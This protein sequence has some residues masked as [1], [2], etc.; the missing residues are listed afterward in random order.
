MTEVLHSE[1]ESVIHGESLLSEHDI[2]LFKEGNHFRMY[3]KL[4]SHTMTVNGREG[5]FF[6]LWAPNA[7]AVSVIGDFNCWDRDSHHLKPR[8][9]GSGIWEGFIPGIK[10]GDTYKYYIASQYHMYRADKGDPYALHW[11]T[12]PKT[13]SIVWDL[14]YEWNDAEWMAGRRARNSLDAP[15]SIY[16]VH[17]GSWLKI[18]RSLIVV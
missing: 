5:T 4:G 2:Y 8:W 17:L 12:P 9:D 13:A 3:D 6:A 7:E 16:E 15:F 11:E 1:R 18:A 10:K 14:A